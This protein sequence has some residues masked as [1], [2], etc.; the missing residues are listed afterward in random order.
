MAKKQKSPL[1]ELVF[2]L[3]GLNR[4]MPY[5]IQAPFT[6]PYALN[7][8]P[9]DVVAGTATNPPN[10]LPS[11]RGRGGSR[12]GLIRFNDS[13]GVMGGATAVQML[14]YAGVVGSNT[15]STNTLLALCGGTLYYS[16]SG[17]MTAATGSFNA[18]DAGMRGTQV[19]PNFY[20]ADYRPA[21]YAGQNGTVNAGG[22]TLT[23]S[24]LTGYTPAVGDVVWVSPTDPTQENVFPV[25]S[26]NSGTNTLTFTN[27]VGNPVTPQAS[28]VVWQVGVMPKY[29]DPIALTVNPLY[30]S[31]IPPQN[32]AT[33]TVSSAAGIVTLTG[34]TFPTL[35]V[36]SLRQG[37][38]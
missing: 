22:L 33:G 5:Q 25:A 28:G 31:P 30:P 23:D 21:S 8:R 4:S 2:P 15:V 12:P 26:F 13:G 38:S 17:V 7:V 14:G 11:Y 6:T 32:Y 36:R 3:G 16:V 35:T 34:G 24:N 27:S 20:I 19:G 1:I 9:F 18:T 29:F 10:S 37:Q